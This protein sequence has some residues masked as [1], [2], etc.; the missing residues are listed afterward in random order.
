MVSIKA[1]AFGDQLVFFLDD[2]CCTL[3]KNISSQRSDVVTKIPMQFRKVPLYDIY[4]AMSA[5]RIVGSMF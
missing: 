4:S 5:C 3:S 2:E 1:I